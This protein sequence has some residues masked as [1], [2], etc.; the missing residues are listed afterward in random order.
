MIGKLHF[1]LN[2][3]DYID[4]TLTV[5]KSIF[6]KKNNHEKVNWLKTQHSFKYF[7]QNLILKNKKDVMSLNFKYAYSNSK[8]LG[9]DFKQIKQDSNDATKAYLDNQYVFQY[10]WML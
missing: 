7:I 5:F 4:C 10:I 3:K 6:I 2:Q 9:V 1:E 8:I